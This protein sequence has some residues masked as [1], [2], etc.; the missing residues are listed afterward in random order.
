MPFAAVG[1]LTSLED[2]PA[3]ASSAYSL[4]THTAGDYVLL[5]TVVN[6]HAATAVSGGLGG[7]TWTQISTTVSL[8]NLGGTGG[9]GFGN[10]WLGKVTSAGTANVTVTFA[11]SLGGSNSRFVARE[12]ST[13]TGVV[14]FDVQGSVTSATANWAS[15]T[16]SKAG[17]LYWGFCEDGSSAVAGST[18]GF[19]YET[20]ANGNGEGYNL[21]VSAPFQ[22]AWGDSTMQA[23][24]MVLIREV[25]PLPAYTASMSSM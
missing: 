2:A 1:S 3:G 5:E 25:F 15:L 11:A 4:T 17:E 12:F 9:A 14:A 22:P 20:D 8:P 13:T 10:V 19:T 24:V 16:P 21:N 18:P 6:T 23:G 7:G